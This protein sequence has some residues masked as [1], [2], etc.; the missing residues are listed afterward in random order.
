M[1]AIK[2]VGFQQMFL[3]QSRHERD[4]KSAGIPGRLDSQWRI[5]DDQAFLRGH[6]QLSCGVEV[7]IGKRLVALG[8]AV[9]DDAIKLSQKRLGDNGF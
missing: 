7:G 1:I 8:V 4:A 9:F 3:R 5:F 6:T 2:N